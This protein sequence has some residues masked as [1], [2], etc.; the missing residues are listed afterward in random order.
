[1]KFVALFVV[2]ALAQDEAAATNP[3]TCAAHADCVEAEKNRCLL[4][5]PTDGEAAGACTTQ[6]AG[7]VLVATPA[8]GGTSAW[9]AEAG[10]YRVGLAAATLAVAAYF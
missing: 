5:T 8:E 10:A 3:A 6:E 7:D 2:A 9:A 4:T 1:M